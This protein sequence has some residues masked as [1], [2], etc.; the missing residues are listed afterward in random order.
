MMN[1]KSQVN[2]WTLR[3]LLCKAVAAIVSI[4][5]VVVVA[6]AMPSAQAQTYTVLYSFTG[7]KDGG[8]PRG[9]LRPDALGN[10]YGTTLYGGTYPCIANGCGV[11]FK[12]DTTGKETVLFNFNGGA[13][14][15]RPVA[16][17][18]R[19]SQGNFYGTAGV[20]GDLTCNAPYGCG[21][22]FKLDTAGTYTVLHSFK[23]SP[24]ASRPLA[25]LLRDTAGNLY[26][27]TEKGGLYDDGAVFKID[28]TGQE[29]V[30]YSF[31]GRRDGA[32][33]LAGLVRD[34]SGNL[35]G[36]T[37]F[38]GDLR[39][40]GSYG[41]GVV[42]KL[43]P[44]GTETV[45]YSFTEHADGGQPATPLLRDK[46]GNLYGTTDFGGD[47]TC[48]APFGCGVVF[49]LDVTGK[50]TVL[51]TF[52]GTPTD[53]EL[54]DGGVIHDGSGNFYG[55]TSQGGAY[56]VGTVF[57]LDKNGV[58]TLL[59]SF[60]G[61]ADGAEPDT[62]LIRDAAGNL[63]GTTILGGMGCPGQGCGVVFKLTP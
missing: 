47:L 31:T 34:A 54:P 26:G 18:I 36:T 52:K 29:T 17:L 62:S 50:E 53:G 37:E 45:L 33:P 6:L 19:D 14:G 48:N 59:Y 11:V 16:G 22:V 8:E 20:G 38:G 3:I 42:F 49:K 27:T 24:D 23:P 57:K 5:A 32:S 58:E 13:S 28:T 40:C 44:T 10:L 15:A 55:T 39:G 56:G 61:G 7:L 51:Y 9:G 35:Y 30:L 41:C 25:P 60:H 63:Y 43:D 2:E 46:A 12:L 21:V 1:N 4:T